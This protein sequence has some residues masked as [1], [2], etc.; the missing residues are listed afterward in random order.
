MCGIIGY[1]G[2]R[3]C[4]DIILDGLERLE[5]RGYDSAG[6]ALLERQGEE[7]SQVHAV[8]NLAKLRA[9]ADE[10][11][12]TATTGLGH[13]RWATHGRVT[14]ENAHPH[15]DQS[16]KVAVV[17]N[18]IIE[19]YVDLR[20]ELA[21]RGVAFTSETDTEVIPHLLA[22][23]YRGDLVQAV[24]DVLPKLEGH[25]AFV[26]MHADE[27]GR[28]VGA[29]KEC[30]LVVGVGDGERFFA[31]AIPAF[32]RETKDI[33]IIESGEIVVLEADST[34]VWNGHPAPIAREVTRVEMDEDAA[35]KGGHDTFMLKEIH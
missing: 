4:K 20:S 2:S 12:S 10:N 13:T 8:G 33:Q 34:T 22:K 23:A 25:Y 31:S 18:G 5:Y 30:P 15:S 35:E 6:F 3:A 28:L 7:F 19:N 26:A 17:M 11:H 16:G 21:G 24:R 29:R 32:L 1:V 27:P 14:E 9:A